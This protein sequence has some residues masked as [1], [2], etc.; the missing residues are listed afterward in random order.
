MQG[1]RSVTALLII[2]GILLVGLSF[3]YFTHTADA[4]PHWL[5]GHQAGLT[6]VHTKHGL[7]SLLLGIGAFIWAWFQSAPKKAA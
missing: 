6:K 5:P 4:L 7:G 1:N 3:V 2:V